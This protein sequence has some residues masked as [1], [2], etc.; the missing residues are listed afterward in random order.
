MRGEGNGTNVVFYHRILRC[1]PLIDL[2]TRAFQHGDAGQM[3]FYLNHPKDNM[4]AESD[5]PPVGIILCPDIFP[6]FLGLPP[7]MSYPLM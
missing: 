6:L 7:Q 3:N 2:K 5:H 1:H 4:L